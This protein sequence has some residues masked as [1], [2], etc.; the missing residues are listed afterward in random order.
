MTLGSGTSLVVLALLILMPLFV[1]TSS[2]SR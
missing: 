2:S 1:R